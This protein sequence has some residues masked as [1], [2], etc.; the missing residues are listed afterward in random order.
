MAAQ[1]LTGQ[2]ATTAV[3]CRSQPSHPRLVPCRLSATRLAQATTREQAASSRHGTL[4]CRPAVS[5]S[6]EENGVQATVE[7]PK[8]IVKIDNQSDRFATVVS[9]QFGDRLGELLDTIGALKNLGLNI[10]RAKIKQTDGSS[11][12]KFYITDAHTSDKI[13]KSARLEE[14]RLTILNNLLYYHPE[15]GEE[16]AWGVR[17]KKPTSRD[18]LNPLGPRNRSAVS[19]SIIITDDDDDNFTE[20]RIETTDR[21]G[22]LTDIVRTLKDIN[23]NV[24]SA[25]IDTEGKVA[26]DHFFVTY[27]GE[28]LPSPM[29]Q[30]VTNALQYYLSLAEIEKEESY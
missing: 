28:P 14:I 5:A 25:E 7:G 4:Q 19:T 8:P 12:N 22:L 13:L 30:L 20:V 16:L 11:I 26:K 21:P 23:V 27:H 1:L 18:A 9:I 6:V 3:I 29:K 15:S 10:R 2:P 17:A 24:I